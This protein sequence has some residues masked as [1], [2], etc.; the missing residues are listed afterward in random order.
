MVS[1]IVCLLICPPS[2]LT[3]MHRATFFF[4]QDNAKG[5]KL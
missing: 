4:R 3:V 1:H 5:R 2:S